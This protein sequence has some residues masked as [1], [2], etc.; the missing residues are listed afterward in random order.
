MIVKILAYLSW[1]LSLLNDVPTLQLLALETFSIIITQ[2]PKSKQTAFG[3]MFYFRWVL[4]TV[5]LL[6][7][8]SPPANKAQIFNNGGDGQNT[9]FCIIDPQTGTTVTNA[10]N[11][12]LKFLSDISEKLPFD[13]LPTKDSFVIGSDSKDFLPIC[14]ERH[15][16]QI[17]PGFYQAQ[18]MR[19]LIR[20]HFFLEDYVSCRKYLAKL[21]SFDATVVSKAFI[22]KA[23]FDAYDKATV[24]SSKK[25]SAL[26]DK[27]A[28]PLYQ[29]IKDELVL[30]HK[31]QQR[32]YDI[33][34]GKNIPQRI[35]NGLPFPQSEE[36][37]KKAD[38]KAMDQ[39]V[40]YLNGT[41][42]VS[43]GKPPSFNEKMD[44]T[45]S[46]GCSKSVRK[47]DL[48][49]AL[50]REK[51][52]DK[53]LKL[54]QD[55]QKIASLSVKKAVY[56]WHLDDMTIVQA[57]GRTIDSDYI[58]VLLAK[59]QQLTQ[60]KAFE[61]STVLLTAA[62]RVIEDKPWSKEKSDALQFLQ[63][64][65]ASLAMNEYQ[66]SRGQ[67]LE[68]S[69]IAKLT[70]EVKECFDNLINPPHQ[71][72]SA[73]QSAAQSEVFE[74]TVATLLNLEQFEFIAQRSDKC[75]YNMVR[76]ASLI[77]YLVCKF[78]KKYYN[79]LEFKD[80]C[81]ALAEVLLP[82][83]Q[84]QGL[85]RSS[86]SHKGE[87]HSGSGNDKQWIK[88]LIRRLHS[89]QILSMLCAFFV[90]YYNSINEDASLEIQC[91]LSPL[92]LTV[93]S[94][95]TI[96]EDTLL[97]FIQMLA[98]N[99]RNPS[100]SWSLRIQGEVH[101]AQGNYLAALQGFVQ[102]LIVSPQFFSKL[103]E[104][105]YFCLKSFPSHN[106]ILEQCILSSR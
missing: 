61:E 75:P 26:T 3:Q 48:L 90:T 58:F 21:K 35:E 93:N 99:C 8:P 33:A 79:T 78:H 20:Y 82:M 84:Q 102:T 40:Q 38:L 10:T 81:K 1:D 15:W 83:L 73:T 74:M 18:V 98:K 103:A 17:P 56:R 45:K 57:A 64:Q 28:A 85:K 91:E 89:P 22:N 13:S 6:N 32:P 11:E 101:Y 65:K 43:Y 77:S 46:K 25:K 86:S 88:R 68:D 27:T 51:R 36:S 23:E 5:P 30:K 71:S 60:M 50:M 55:F 53:I 31:G 67:G 24:K 106:R 14:S 47:R 94:S 63:L 2:D 95:V 54:I 44:K 29:Q 92:P 66:N 97:S 34:L 16:A 70:A 49:L 41:K 104:M 76:L 12:A 59:V 42:A 9:P 96:H 72:A 87:S 80:K 4:S 39:L 19:D 52:P 62:K 37:V 7:F 105:Q 100:L 69:D